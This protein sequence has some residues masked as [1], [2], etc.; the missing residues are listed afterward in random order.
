MPIDDVPDAWRLGDQY[1]AYIGR[2]SRRVA[3]LFLA[4]LGIPPGRRWLDVGCGT[5]ALTAAIW[6]AAAPS[7]LT[8]VDPSE[9]FL[10]TA[11]ERLPGAVTLLPGEGTRIPLPD[12]SVDV[13]VSGLVLNFIADQDAALREM[14][15]VTTAGGTVAAYVWDYAE[16]MELLRIFWDAAAG[17]DPRAALLDEGLRFPGCR[18]D[19]LVELFTGAGLAAAEATALDIPTPFDSFDAYW[20]SF[21]GG[22]GP[23]PSFVASLTEEGRGRLRESIRGRVPTEADGSIRLRARAWAV[24]GEVGVAPPR[25]VS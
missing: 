23:A 8:A 18:P 17:L 24:R 16:G 3:P 14:A 22:Q 1:E 12:R 25:P 2:W 4:W 20:D 7:E 10:R 9:G 11:R 21:L 19:T 15:R 6:E 5:G 13:A